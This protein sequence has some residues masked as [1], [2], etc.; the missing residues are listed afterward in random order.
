MDGRVLDRTHGIIY[1]LTLA[2]DVSL[3]ELPATRPDASPEVVIQR[4]TVPAVWEITDPLN[5]RS[6]VDGTPE[7]LWLRVPD[8]IRMLIRGGSSLTFE[9][10]GA[11]G[12]D[13]AR[14]FLL[15]SGLGGVLMQRGFVVLHGNA[16]TR[17]GSRNALMCIGDS[18]AGKSTTAIAMT[19]RGFLALADDV[20]PIDTGGW[21]APG[22]PH[23]KLWQNTAMDFGIDPAS[24]V[25]L[26][27][28]ETKFYVPLGAFHCPEPRQVNLFIW[29]VPADTTR[30]E[31]EEITGFAKFV[32]LRNNL[33]RPEYLLPLQLSAAGLEQVSR[34][35]ARARVY[36]VIRPF[37]GS[38]LDPLL[39]VISNLYD[40]HETSFE[41]PRDK[42]RPEA[43]N[44]P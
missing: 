7:Q 28:R 17:A 33:Y 1:G 5:V 29:L 13:A 31:I 32:V 3:P 30:V 14:P 26:R 9:L 15:G 44:R 6:I 25:P 24:L 22:M 18:G 23:V 10:E 8:V 21:A 40:E 39:D 11:G 16:I 12:L 19:R 27:T 4:G 35:A 38:D 41:A 36:K 34:L 20:C 37:A 43:G 42:G 2:S